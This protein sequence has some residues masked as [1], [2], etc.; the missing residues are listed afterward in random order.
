LLQIAP[1]IDASVN[2][3][4][5]EGNSLN[6]NEGKVINGK[7][8][9]VNGSLNANMPVFNGMNVINTHRQASNN[10][11]AQ[12]HQVNR[13]SQDVIRDV[14]LNTSP[15]LLDQELIRIDQ[16]NICYGK[17]YSMTRSKPR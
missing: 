17:N 15:A 6:Q 7:I 16:E 8:D 11:E 5:A 2:A 3:Y 4:R 14:L 12:L 1:S 13:S 9:Y 10:N